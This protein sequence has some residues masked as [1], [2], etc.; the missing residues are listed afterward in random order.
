MLMFYSIFMMICSACIF[1]A[2]LLTIQNS[3]INAICTGV[4]IIGEIIYIT[5]QDNHETNIK[6]LQEEIKKIK[7]EINKNG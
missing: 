4:F 6:E 2:N 3:L 1:T 5:L 7:K